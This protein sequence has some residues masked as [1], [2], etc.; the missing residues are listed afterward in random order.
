MGGLRSAAR[1]HPLTLFY[2][3]TLAFS[4]WPVPLMGGSLLPHGPFLAA[5]L[6]LGLTEG[7]RGLAELFRRVGK[8][9]VAWYWY[10]VAPGLVIGYLLVALALNL[11]LGAR[12]AETAHLRSAGVVAGLVLELLIVGGLWEEPGWAGYALPRLQGRYAVR[13][14]GLLMASLHLGA[15]RALW[16]LPLVMYGHIPWFDAVFFSVALQF[17]ITWL[18]N[19]TRGS[20]LIVMLAHLTSNVV[21]GSIMVPLFV[22]DDDVR[23]Y[24]LFVAAAFLAALLLVSRGGWGMGRSMDG[25]RGKP[26]T[27]I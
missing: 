24:I 9:R 22:G 8:W 1:G 16:H 26:K 25:E 10:L 14:Y 23:F 4:W 13:P 20:V 18:F 5:L 12:I 19:R 27:A 15:L 2:V 6:V 11:L 21:G 3:V 17:L 7:R